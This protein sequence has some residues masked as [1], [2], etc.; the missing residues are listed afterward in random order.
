MDIHR[1]RFVDYTPHTITAMAFSHASDTH[2]PS[3]HSL[4]LAVGRSNGD[5]EIWSPKHNWTHELTLPGARGRAIEGL[6]WAHAQGENPRL[7]SIGGS[8]FVTEWDLSLLRPKLNY[9]CN[10]GVVWC[11][12]TNAAG[13]KLA[14]G[15]DDG[16]VVLVDI[17]GG[18]GVMEHD[19]ICQRQDLRVLG[20]KWHDADLLVGGC[21]DGKVR[22]WAAQGDS[23]G[24]IVSSMKVDKLRTELTLVWSIVCLPQRGQFVTG[25][26]TG[27]VKVWDAKTFTLLQGFTAHEADVL[28][29]A[30]DY[31]GSTIYSAGIDRKIHQYTW[32]QGQKKK[33]L[34]WIHSVSRLLHSNDVR[35]LAMYESKTQNLLVS[36]G[37][38]RAMIV[39]HSDHFLQGSYKK[40]LMLQQLLNIRV[41]GLSK[42]VALFQD[43][44]VKI[45][46]IL[47]N[48]GK[49]KLVAKL[50]L[51]DDD[52]ITSVSV[53]VSAGALSFLAVATINTVKVF[54]LTETELKL[55][56]R[57]IRDEA[58]SEVVSGAKNVQIYDHANLLVH[59]PEDELYRF[60]ISE[61]GIELDDEIESVAEKS[62]ETKA[63]YDFCNSIKHLV[64]SHDFSAVVVA[65]F[66]NTVEVLPLNGN[67][68][69]VVTKLSSPVHLMDITGANTLV[70]LTDENKL[71]ELSLEENSPR[72][73][74]DWSQ[75]NSE[76]TPASLAKSIDKPQG[77]FVEQRKVWVYGSDW[78]AFFD[79]DLDLD[80]VT[81]KNRKRTRDGENKDKEDN[82]EEKDEE[83]DD[84]K[85]EIEQYSKR[86]LPFWLTRKY[87]PIL[88]VAVWGDNEIT[89]VEREAFSLPT[90]SAFEAAHLKV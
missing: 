25:D 62:S 31:S 74:T 41:R 81:P 27:A 90:T 28:T 53:G 61:Q 68:G 21:A 64:I 10:A 57:K 36:G 48:E 30:K 71:L 39:Q 59:T 50:S 67:Q 80:K 60:T 88:K 83:K 1:C 15:C 40:V 37:V 14:V 46:R 20:I 23:R 76:N 58:F 77:L 47:E 79:L 66:D 56:V 72:L 11:L 38:E 51:A 70:V 24:R 17:S 35:A 75:R 3:P 65:R 85:S 55:K 8:T 45:W 26:S 52:N 73:L 82:E 49:H 6:V 2:Q 87:R 34:R 13:D 33:S 16:S 9:D 63:G 32:L 84:E 12:D 78:L 54:A 43:Q 44:T 4:K 69:Y 19:L 89:V 18:S 7:F 86:K 5:I 29:L 22:C 42:L